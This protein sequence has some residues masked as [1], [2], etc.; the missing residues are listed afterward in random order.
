[1]LVYR[2]PSAING[3][4]IIAIVTGARRPSQ[5][6]KTGD[7]VQLWILPADV[8][9]VSA[10]RTGADE[11]VCGDCPLRPSKRGGCYVVTF[12]GPL[13]TWR[14]YHDSV[15]DLDGACAAIAR[16]GIPIRL[17][18]Y[19]DIAALPEGVVERLASAATGHTGYTHQWRQFPWARKYAQASVESGWDAYA[20]WRAGWRTY[21]IASTPMPGEARCSS[22]RMSCRECRA[23]NGATSN[24]VN[25]PHG[26]AR[27]RLSML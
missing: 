22:D 9:P 13:S 27:R 21:R 12:Q 7:M 2:G 4:L 23:C 24:R 26:K 14:A 6:R 16:A 3:E 11:A 25:A 8:D 10:Q 15:P 1:V 17:G 19:G 18:A 5:N 20:A